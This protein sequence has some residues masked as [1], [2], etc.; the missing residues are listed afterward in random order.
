MTTEAEERRAVSAATVVVQLV[1]V[2]TG[3]QWAVDGAWYS[4]RPTNPEALLAGARWLADT[5]VEV[6]EAVGRHPAAATRFEA[7]S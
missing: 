7:P 2:D 5:A 4:H 1:I 6:H 3:L